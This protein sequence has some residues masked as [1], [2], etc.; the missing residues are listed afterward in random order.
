MVLRLLL[1]VHRVPD[2]VGDTPLDT[3]IR[4]EPDLRVPDHR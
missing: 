2:R 1:F 3:F 4:L